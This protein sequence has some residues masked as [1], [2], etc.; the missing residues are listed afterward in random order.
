MGRRAW[1]VLIAVLLLIAGITIAFTWP[2]AVFRRELSIDLNSGRLQER[3]FVLGVPVSR[4]MQESVISRELGDA[5]AG[6]PSDWQIVQTT[7]GRY[8]MRRECD[9]NGV[10]SQVAN[11]EFMWKMYAFAGPARHR[12]ARDLL[13]MWRTQSHHEASLYLRIV[14]RRAEEAGRLADLPDPANLDREL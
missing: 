3:E 14:N 12:L 8:V 7:Y 2:G 1:S 6:A 11:L 4:H 9:G 13:E 5:A 10:P